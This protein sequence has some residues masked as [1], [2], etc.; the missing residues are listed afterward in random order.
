MIE[1]SDLELGFIQG[2]YEA[3]DCITKVIRSESSGET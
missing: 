3:M 2:L 1:K